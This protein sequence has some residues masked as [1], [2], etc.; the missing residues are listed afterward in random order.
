MTLPAFAVT[1]ILTLL[2][3]RSA[4]TTPPQPPTHRLLELARRFAP[5]F[6]KARDHAGHKGTGVLLKVTLWR[7]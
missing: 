5:T 4:V 7:F 3:A 2:P 1:A 6:V